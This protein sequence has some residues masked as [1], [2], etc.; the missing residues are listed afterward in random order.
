[1]LKL[2]RSVCKLLGYELEWQL[3][4]FGKKTRKGKKSGQS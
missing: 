3:G 4:K 1:M 2:V